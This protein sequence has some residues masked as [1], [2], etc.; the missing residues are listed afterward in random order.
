MVST[1]LEITQGIDE[2]VITHSIN[3]PKHYSG[4]QISVY[5]LRPQ[6]KEERF[7]PVNQ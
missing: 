6:L 7:I 2:P 5:L 4:Y 1:N 3:K